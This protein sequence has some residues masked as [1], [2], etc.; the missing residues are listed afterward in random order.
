MHPTR[1]A[2]LAMV[3]AMTTAAAGEGV[4]A[5][6]VAERDPAFGWERHAA[7]RFDG[8]GGL[9][10]LALRSQRWNGRVWRHWVG[11]I[12]PARLSHPDAALLLV[13]GGDESAEP[14]SAESREAAALR[15]VAAEA[16]TW[17]VVV[18]RV[19]NQPLFDGLYEDDLIAH[20]FRR[21][22]DGETDAR[23]VALLPMVKSAA[24]AMDA[25]AALA[26]AEHGAPIERFT[27]TGASKR[28]WTS[29]LAAAVD[30]RVRA[31]APIV[32][33]M[34]NMRAQLESQRRAYGR[35]SGKLE[36]YKKRGIPR[37]LDTEAGERLRRIVDPFAYRDRLEQPKLAVLGTNDPYWSLDAANRYAP[38]MPGP[39][40]R[41]Y[42]A[43]AGHEIRPRGAAAI[44]R[45][46][47]TV[48]AGA[49]FPEISTS[50]PD[51][52]PQRLRVRWSAERVT[53]I[54][55]RA[56]APSRDLRDARWRAERL[57]AATPPHTVRVEVPASG[58]RAYYV[59]LRFDLG[60]PVPGG[61]CSRVSVLG[62]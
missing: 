30:Q 50:H 25:A 59:E 6:Y 10:T 40:H 61:V 21:F 28:G 13:K 4:L 3:A 48:T 56:D 11:V 1:S 49:Q 47:Q 38:E 54:L 23:G 12:R 22:L 36:P 39:M 43:N 42:Q 26:A 33:D 31:V 44:A 52:D 34:V 32:F 14:P 16:G 20:T 17:A 62:E 2:A 57:S 35:L 7:R 27:L 18:D 41:Y 46:H 5:R 29:W 15:R 60:S 45:F 37:S 8:G 9:W 51:G 19:P 53:P 58:F 55:W 24:A